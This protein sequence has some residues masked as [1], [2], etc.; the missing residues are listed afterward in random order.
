MIWSRIVATGPPSKR[1]IGPLSKRC[2]EATDGQKGGLTHPK[3]RFCALCGPSGMLLAGLVQF[4]PSVWRKLDGQNRIEEVLPLCSVHI[5][6]NYPL[7]LAY[8]Q[9][10]SHRHTC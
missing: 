3:L 4:L 9:T 2:S 7:L 1:S 5:S 6:P 10:M 8:Q